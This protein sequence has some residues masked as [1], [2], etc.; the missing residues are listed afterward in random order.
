MSFIWRK[1]RP[2]LR[3]RYLSLSSR[4]G[5]LA[6]PSLK[7][8]QLAAQLKLII[9]WFIDDPRSTWL[10][11]ES[12]TLDTIRLCNLQYISPAKAANLT[13][14]NVVLRNMLSTWRKIR[15]LEGH[16]NSFLLLT[17]L[18]ENPD[19]PPGLKCSPSSQVWA[20]RL[21]V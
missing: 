16:N 4:L 9:E 14:N 5:G 20:C 18:H 7:C 12:V 8:Y 19:F 13:K 3:Y 11:S 6:T 21:E 10:S 1:K 15:R 17:P 2:R